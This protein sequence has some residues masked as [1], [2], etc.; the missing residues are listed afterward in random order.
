MSLLL[1]AL[2]H[3]ESRPKKAS[4]QKVRFRIPGQTLIVCKQ[5]IGQGSAAESQKTKVS[6]LLLLLFCCILQV[7]AAPASA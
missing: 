2:M 4:A 6:Q 1:G 5:E 7:K 3:S